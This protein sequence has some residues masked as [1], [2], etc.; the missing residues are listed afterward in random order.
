MFKNIIL[1]ILL[2]LPLAATSNLQS[3]IDCLAK[4]IYY[5]ARGES[6]RGK[7][8]VALATLNR[9]DSPRYPK[10]ICEVVYQ[11]NQFSWTRKQSKSTKWQE[12]RYLAQKAYDNRD[13]LGNFKATHFHNL[14]VNPR[15][16]LKR[17]TKIG[18]H[19]FYV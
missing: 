17:L 12:S 13:I 2:S 16:K 11:K 7:L 8:A 19:I 9:V 1:T 10:T 3:D 5:E 18:G 14:R 15:W 6:E 4:V